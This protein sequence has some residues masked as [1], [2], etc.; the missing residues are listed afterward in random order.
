MSVTFDPNARTV[1]IPAA[2]VGPL[3]GFVFRLAVDTAATHTSLRPDYLRR[4]GYDLMRPVEHRRV[5]SATGTVVAPVFRVARI[6]ALDQVRT[7]L[8][9]AAQNLP[10]GVEAD[11]LL[12]LDF[13][14]GL[15][16]TLDFAR[17]RASL[18]AGRRWQFW[19]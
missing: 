9:V 8:L 1:L 19:R 6:E 18:R 15:V 7:D 13:F 5:R 17:G 16:L 4:L 14:R 11:G 2:V 10:L 3:Q 12:G